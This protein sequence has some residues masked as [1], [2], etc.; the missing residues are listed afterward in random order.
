MA[1][2]KTA[3]TDNPHLEEGYK[4]RLE[5]P[6]YV[7]VNP[8]TYGD[9]EERHEAGAERSDIPASSIPWLLE[10]GHIARKEGN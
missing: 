10:Q 4:R 9:P 5:A 8:L 3:P 7:V 1:K 2:K 6:V